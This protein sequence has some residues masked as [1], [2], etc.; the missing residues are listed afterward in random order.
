M[1]AGIDSFFEVLV[2]LAC[3]RH[4]STLMNYHPFFFGSKFLIHCLVPIESNFIYENVRL[5]FPADCHYGN[6]LERPGI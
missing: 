1:L 5:E 2:V 6:A 3:E 4:F